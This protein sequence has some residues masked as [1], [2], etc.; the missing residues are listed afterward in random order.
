MRKSVFTKIVHI[1]LLMSVVI[2]LVASPCLPLTR[3]VYA[4]GDIVV[5]LNTNDSVVNPGDIVTINVVASELCNIT[6]FGDI[7]LRFPQDKV[8]FVSMAQPME[9][10]SFSYVC[11]DPSD[12]ALV[13]AAV[14]EV[15]EAD[16]DTGGEDQSV[17]FED[18][19]TLF[20]ASFR[21]NTQSS[22]SLRFWLET[23]DGFRNS[24][25]EEFSAS[26]GDGITVTVEDELSSD[27]TLMNLE[28]EGVSLTPAFSPDV[29]E[30]STSV[31]SQ[32]TEI[33]IAAMS[34]NLSAQVAI[35]DTSLQLGENLIIITVTA[36]DGTT[37]NE[38]KL[39]VTRQESFF[40]E[41]TGLVDSTGRTFT[42]V[43]V[44]NTYDLPDGFVST[45]RVINGYTVPVFVR[46]GV[47]SYL[48]YMYDGAGEPGFYFYNPTTKVVTRYNT[49]NYAIISSRVLTV[50]PV[51]D[52]VKIPS[53]FEPSTLMTSDGVLLE[54]FVNENNVFIA[55]MKDEEGNSS[56]YRY[57]SQSGR[58]YDYKTVDKTAE[59]IYGIFFRVFLIISLVEAVVI[60]ATVYLIRRII[61]NRNNPRP[62]RV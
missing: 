30:Y 62:R 54:G 52:A 45:T 33:E 18:S 2:G 6:R 41:G 14:D 59:R 26:I 13:V 24:S 53:G 31:N 35:S 3:D 9:L 37:V 44:P 8:E 61:A 5:T 11:N 12:G 22:D 32:V 1:V 36:Q 46:E 43:A 40:A 57:D 29:F 27:A 47:T 4:D 28:V 56:F 21:V 7:T 39:Y 34:R 16:L 48:I 50:V 19:V 42:F 38:Y 17:Y 51:P 58:F 55:Y 10:G 15:V 25:G 20:S 23:A 60:I 49:D